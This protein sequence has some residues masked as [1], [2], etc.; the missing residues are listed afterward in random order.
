MCSTSHTPLLKRE[1]SPPNCLLFMSSQSFS[2]LSSS[3]CTDD[4][5]LGRMRKLTQPIA[6][7]SWPAPPMCH[8]VLPFKLVHNECM[9]GPC[10]VRCVERR[11]PRLCLITGE[12]PPLVQSSPSTCYLFFPQCCSSGYILSAVYYWYFLS[13][14]TSL[15]V[16]I[17]WQY[18][19]KLW[20]TIKWAHVHLCYPIISTF[21]YQFPCNFIHL[22]LFS[23]NFHPP[24]SVCP[25]SSN[26]STTLLK[27]G[28]VQW[29]YLSYKSDMVLH[30]I[31]LKH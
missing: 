13:Q 20:D 6:E 16:Q 4:K 3:L 15:V 2:A 26:S 19:G 9:T 14:W 7:R 10:Y 18:P 31:P 8:S 30:F 25:S 29:P 11:W 17:I 5:C 22:Y 28:P 27:T 23:S 1:P 21:I 12:S 24:W